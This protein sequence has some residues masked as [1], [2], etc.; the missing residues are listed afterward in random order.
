[1]NQRPAVDELL[2]EMLHQTDDAPTVAV[3]VESRD[4][5][6]VFTS[7]DV[8]LRVENDEEATTSRVQLLVVAVGLKSAFNARLHLSLVKRCSDGF[9]DHFLRIE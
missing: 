6:S 3:D 9:Y 7:E 5:H 4:A 1:M 2:V 8:E